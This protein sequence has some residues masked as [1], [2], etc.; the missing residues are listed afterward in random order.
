MP[1]CL[2]VCLSAHISQNHCGHGSILSDDRAISYVI[3]VL[4]MTSG[5]L[6]IEPIGQNQKTTSCFVEFV[7]FVVHGTYIL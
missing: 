2:S 1:S 5:F 6:I 3:L 7:V 4:W